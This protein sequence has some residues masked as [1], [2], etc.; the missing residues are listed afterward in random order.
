MWNLRL[1]ITL[2]TVSR[3][4]LWDWFKSC[5]SFNKRVTK[6]TVT[7]ENV[8]QLSGQSSVRPNGGKG[9]T[10]CNPNFVYMVIILV[11][12]LLN[13]SWKVMKGHCN[14]SCCFVN[15]YGSEMC[16]FSGLKSDILLSLSFTIQLQIIN[17]LLYI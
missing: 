8:S 14:S 10:N 13:L 2:K 6:V 15:I 5:Q 9:K 1:F 12:I 4:V 7:L 3:H 16:Y 11:S 17:P